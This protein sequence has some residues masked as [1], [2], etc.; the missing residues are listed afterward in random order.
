MKETPIKKK[1]EAIVIGASA[2]GLAA[3]TAILPNLSKFLALPVIVVQHL[4]PDSDDFLAT[5]FN[6]ICSLCVKEAEDKEPIMDNTIYFAPANYH[7][8]VEQ[9]KTIALSTAERVQYSRPAI[10]VLFETAADAYADRLIGIILTGSNSDGTKGIQRI[11]ELKGLV[12]AQSPESA[13][14]NIMPLSAINQA[15]VDKILDL[16]EIA[17]Y[18]NQIT[19][20]ET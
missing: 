6:R 18:I 2:G 20:K 15:G 8:M 1:Y 7:L 14:V 19:E 11:R 16:K 12:I 3:L 10:D 13:Q 5:H 17:P 9:D 4:S